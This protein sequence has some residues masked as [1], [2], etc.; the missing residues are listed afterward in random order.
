MELVER[1]FAS[2]VASD[3]HG[4]SMRTPWMEEVHGMLSETVSPRCAQVLLEEN[5]RK[6]LKN[7]DVLPVVPEWFV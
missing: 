4:A 3:A 2:V 7:E 1:G 6:I 5:P